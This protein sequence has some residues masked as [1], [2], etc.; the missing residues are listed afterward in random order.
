MAHQLHSAEYKTRHDLVR[1]SSGIQQKHLSSPQRELKRTVPRDKPPEPT[2]A[3][4]IPQEIP[5]D[6]VD[7]M[8][9]PTK[10]ALFSMLDSSIRSGAFQ[11]PFYPVDA[12]DGPRFLDTEACLCQLRPEPVKGGTVWW[13]CVGNQFTITDTGGKWFQAKNVDGLKLDTNS[14]L[15]PIYDASYPPDSAEGFEWDDNQQQLTITGDRTPGLSV[16]DT[17]CTAENNTLFSTTLYRA[18][19]EKQANQTPVDAAPCW[20]PGAIP[21]QIQ[22]YKD[23]QEHGCKDGFLCTLIPM[24]SLTSPLS[25]PRQRLTRYS[26]VQTTPSTHYHSTVLPSPNASLPD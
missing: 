6:V 25:T 15:G 19:A 20:R 22:D 12:V 10:I 13:Q 4:D 2:M 1:R 24:P 7:D 9:T 21:I 16:W 18:A 26:Q 11:D 17:A 14:T 3:Q 5:Q 23:W 8:T